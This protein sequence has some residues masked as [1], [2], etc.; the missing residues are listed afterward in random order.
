MRS[1]PTRDKWLW[2]GVSVISWSVACAI[3]G[4]LS[5][6]LG[7]YPPYVVNFPIVGPITP[8]ELFYGIFPSPDVVIFP[9][10]GLISGLGQGIILRPRLKGSGWWALATFT[11]L[12]LAGVSCVLFPDW[13]ANPVGAELVA[14]VAL[15]FLLFVTALAIGIFQWLI[16]FKQAQGAG[17]WVWVSILSWFGGVVGLVAGWALLAM[18]LDNLGIYNLG[19]CCSGVLG[20]IVTIMQDTLTG[21]I[22]GASAGAGAGAISGFGLGLWWFRNPHNNSEAPPN[23]AKLTSSGDKKPSKNNFQFTG[24]QVDRTTPNP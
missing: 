23:S 10:A 22:I 4:A 15:F 14:F 12:A 1:I 20:D 3:A 8:S 7:R 6:L 21:A 9:I 2:L 19:A 5:S 11:G 18:T 16:L 13:F 24:I 17:S